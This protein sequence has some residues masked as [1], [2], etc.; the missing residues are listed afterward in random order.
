MLCVENNKVE[1]SGIWPWR[2]TH[3][4]RL[5]VLGTK[6]TWSEVE[7]CWILFCSSCLQCTT[8][9]KLPQW[10]TA[11]NL[12]L[13]WSLRCLMDFLH[14]SVLLSVFSR[15]CALV[16]PGVGDH[17]SVWSCSSPCSSWLFLTACCQAPCG[18]G[19]GVLCPPSIASTLGR[20]LGLA[21]GIELSQHSLYLP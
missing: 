19:K 10:W 17:L 9:F 11:V 20:T 15:S 5:L 3:L 7:L 2:D 13:G 12:C 21:S 1:V 6:S 16:L 14:V 8:D 4:I 18:A